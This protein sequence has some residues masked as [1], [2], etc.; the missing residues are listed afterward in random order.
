MLLVFK[1]IRQYHN[2]T[3]IGHY[4]WVSTHAININV[5]PHVF[6]YHVAFVVIN[7]HNVVKSQQ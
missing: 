7:T 1:S 4:S 6:L 5:S 2:N 3:P